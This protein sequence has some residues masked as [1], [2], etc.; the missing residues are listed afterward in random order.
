MSIPPTPFFREFRGFLSEFC[1]E[2]AGL[3][4]FPFLLAILL[5]FMLEPLGLQVRKI[6]RFGFGITL[7]WFVGIKT[8]PIINEFTEIFAGK[9][10][11]SPVQIILDP[12]DL[13]AQFVACMEI[14]GNI[15]N[16]TSKGIKD[17]R[18]YGSCDA[19]S[20]SFPQRG[21]SS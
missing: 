7:I 19:R 1:Q 15:R 20:R 21:L 9:L 8:I 5:G 13:L 4:F 2:N 12:T 18:A 10:V 6:G 16:P 11:G 14:M 17:H 3:L